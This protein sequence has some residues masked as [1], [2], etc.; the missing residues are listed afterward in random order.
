MMITAPRV[1]F[2]AL[3]FAASA[4]CAPRTFRITPQR[5]IEQLR[6]EALAATPPVETPT[7]RYA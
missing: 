7:A 4:G 3:L 1:I 2:A 5:P 6:T